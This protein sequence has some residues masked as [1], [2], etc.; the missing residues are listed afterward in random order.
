M[1]VDNQ[2]E[3][4]FLINNFY[5]IIFPCSTRFECFTRSSSGALPNILYHTVWYSILGS[6]PD[7]ERVKHSKRVEQEKTME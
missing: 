6:A 5:S 1:C 3:A 2:R 4:Q 7:D